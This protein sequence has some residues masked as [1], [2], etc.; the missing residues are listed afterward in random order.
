MGCRSVWSFDGGC[1]IFFRIKSRKHSDLVIFQL[2]STS[3]VSDVRFRQIGHFRHLKSDV[4]WRDRTSQSSDLRKIGGGKVPETRTIRRASSPSLK[5]IRIHLLGLL[6]YLKT[7]VP[8]CVC[9]CACVCVCMC[10]VHVVGG[11]SGCAHVCVCVCVCRMC[12][13]EFVCHRIV[14]TYGV[15]SISRL[16]KI[17]SLFCKRAL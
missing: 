3:D 9:V 17:I 13:S 15:A 16:L 2:F 4:I 1:G 10:I 12:A 7:A 11:S 6:T 8:T 14:C 5:D